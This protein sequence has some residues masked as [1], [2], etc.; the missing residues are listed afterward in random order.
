V[1]ARAD[2]G[3][4]TVQSAV[5]G[6][7]GHDQHLIWPAD[8][9][10]TIW[11]TLRRD[12]DREAGWALE[13]YG[14]D[15]PDFFPERIAFA[16]A[17]RDRDEVIAGHEAGGQ[18]SRADDP[19]AVAAQLMA[20]IQGEPL[21]TADAMRLFSHRQVV[22]RAFAEELEPVLDDTSHGMSSRLAK[23]KAAYATGRDAAIGR[24]RGGVD[25]GEEAAAPASDSGSA[26]PRDRLLDLLSTKGPFGAVEAARA[27]DGGDL[28]F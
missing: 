6:T 26:D 5:Y 25:S 21:S 17:H 16:E 18:Y 8:D 1:E 9:G 14:P 4:I 24:E 28:D 12:G 19:G 22:A 11:L 7:N 13:Q 20:S 2:S 3:L 27:V 15:S 10:G 23:A